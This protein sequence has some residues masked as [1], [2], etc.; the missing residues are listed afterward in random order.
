VS[1]FD[2]EDIADLSD[3]ERRSLRMQI[4]RE[5]SERLGNTPAEVIKSY[6]DPGVWNTLGL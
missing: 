4:A 5:I 3:S 6:V 2:P 1:E